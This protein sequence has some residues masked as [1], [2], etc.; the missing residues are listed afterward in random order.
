M[1]I[2]CEKKCCHVPDLSTSTA[3]IPEKDLGTIRIYEGSVEFQGLDSGTI[4]VRS[5]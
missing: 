1:L 5:T 4:T 3:P 2:S